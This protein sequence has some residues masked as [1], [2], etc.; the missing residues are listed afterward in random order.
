MQFEDSVRQQL[1]RLNAGRSADLKRITLLE[2]ARAKLEGRTKTSVFAMPHTAVK[3][4]YLN[5]RDRD[6]NFRE[7]EEQI[8]RL[9]VT[10]RE[11]EAI[12]SLSQARDYLDRAAPLAARKII[13]QVRGENDRLGL[14]A[15]KFIVNTTG[16]NKA[17]SEKTI[18]IDQGHDMIN[19]VLTAIKGRIKDDQLL[20]EIANDFRLILS[21]YEE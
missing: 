1:D 19:K 21:E 11:N 15:A 4:T 3:K 14:D 16:L 2:L 5:W 12:R 7:V 13:Q 20:A 10:W 6:P 8:E 17:E 18:T 9:S